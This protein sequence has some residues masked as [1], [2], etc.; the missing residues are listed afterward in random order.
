VEVKPLDIDEIDI[1]RQRIAELH[2][3]KDI[4]VEQVLPN[5]FCCFKWCR[6]KEGKVDYQI[7]QDEEEDIMEVDERLEQIILNTGGRKYCGTSVI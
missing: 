7:K 4:K 1:A 6:K 5:L 3:L 2:P